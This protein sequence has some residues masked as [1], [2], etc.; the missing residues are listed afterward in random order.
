MYHTRF[1]FF[2]RYVRTRTYSILAYIRVSSSHDF[3]CRCGW[4]CSD[5]PQA[6]VGLRVT[7][8][9]VGLISL[10]WDAPKSDGGSAVTGYIIEICRSGS[11]TGWTTGARVDGS[12]QSAEL[13]VTISLDRDVLNL[14]VLV[15][16]LFFCCCHCLRQGRDESRLVGD[17]RFVVRSL[18]NMDYEQKSS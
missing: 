9:N 12:C 8:T 16:I 3:V 1:L 6:P 7:G 4:L 2:E 5:V 13:T 17:T 11:T 15:A 10:A 14:T 18:E